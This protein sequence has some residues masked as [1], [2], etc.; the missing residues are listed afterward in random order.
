[1][2][3]VGRIPEEVWTRVLSFVAATSLP[4][5]CA[6]RTVNHA[7]Y[8]L[9]CD[10]RL[11]YAAYCGHHPTWSSG[12]PYDALPDR[13]W[14]TLLKEDYALR[15]YW[16]ARN[17]ASQENAAGLTE[18]P[19]RYLC[20]TLDPRPGYT[21]NYMPMLSRFL[22]VDYVSSG[23]GIMSTAVF[24]DKFP[25]SDVVV[26]SFPQHRIVYRELLQPQGEDPEE[27]LEVGWLAQLMVSVVWRD[28]RWDQL[29][30]YDISVHSM[31]RV[32]SEFSLQVDMAGSQVYVLPTWLQRRA[33]PDAPSEVVLAGIER[34][35]SMC[36]LL[37]RHSV[38]TGQTRQ[39]VFT[40]QTS[41]IYF[42]S[43]FPD[44]VL[45]TDDLQTLRIWCA[46][47]G[48]LLI[49]ERMSPSESLLR[50]TL[51]SAV[52]VAAAQR[53]VSGRERGLRLVTC[54][55][56]AEDKTAYLYV[57]E[58]DVARSPVEAQNE[59]QRRDAERG[60]DSQT[61]TVVV[62]AAQEDLEQKITATVSDPMLSG[63]RGVAASS[64]T[65]ILM[66]QPQLD[67]QGVADRRVSLT[68]QNDNA[69]LRLVNVK[70][71]EDTCV[72]FRVMGSLLF[73]ARE[74]EGEH[75]CALAVVIDLETGKDVYQSRPIGTWGNM[76]PLGRELLFHTT[77]SMFTI[78]FE[79]EADEDSV[80]E[81]GREQEEPLEPP[82]PPLLTTPDILPDGVHMPAQ[83]TAANP[84]FI[85]IEDSSQETTDDGND[86]GNDELLI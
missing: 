81:Y 32:V 31:P 47:T 18:E 69:T 33:D 67:Q 27:M 79:G 6:V 46:Y 16:H 36:G 24:S 13:D 26:W 19:R 56:S 48:R 59:A 22:V 23:S 39:F 65:S 52:E 12:I 83:V 50:V 66:Q 55:R 62:A 63:A 61:G 37:I 51:T 53:R 84:N 73:A 41:T 80:V 74:S 38:R 29:R 8:R 11:W 64:G 7:F 76:V 15:A 21:R 34:G 68:I 70:P 49:M 9:C 58:L 78:G 20:R 10:S 1:M 77:N 57:W 5:L 71:L 42:D 85:I 75:D 60:V 35:D 45:T 2:S 30:V 28:N 14:R 25:A 4:D 82:P 3:A 43:R 86:D 17:K 72:V 44:L 40:P 54:T